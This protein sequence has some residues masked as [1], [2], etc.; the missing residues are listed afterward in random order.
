MIK[1]ITALLAVLV[2]A[3]VAVAPLASAVSQ[4][5]RT[6]TPKAPFQIGSSIYAAAHIQGVYAGTNQTMQVRLLANGS[7]LGVVTSYPLAAGANY[8]SD[9]STPRTCA[10]G[11]VKTYVTQVRLVTNSIATP[12]DSG[13]GKN[14]VC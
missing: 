8:N 14:F 3:L 12:W 9:V 11:T 4:N 10:F 1:R 6:A 13:P 2:V 7:Q 5:G